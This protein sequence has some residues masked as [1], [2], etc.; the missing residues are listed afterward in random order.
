MAGQVAFSKIYNIETRPEEEEIILVPYGCTKLRILQFPVIKRA[1]I[2]VIIFSA[3][4]EY[5][6][7]RLLN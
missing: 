7:A 5:G 1:K 3:K 4:L 6:Q 2:S